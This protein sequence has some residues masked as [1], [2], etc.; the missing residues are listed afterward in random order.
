MF[1][2][3]LLATVAISASA[4]ELV[5]AEDDIL[6]DDE[7]IEVMEEEAPA[8]EA[9]VDDAAED[10]VAEDDALMDDEPIEEMEEEAPAVEAPVDE[11]PVEEALKLEAPAKVDQWKGIRRQYDADRFGPPGGYAADRF[12]PPGGY[13]ADRFGPPG[14]LKAGKL[15][16]RKP[17]PLRRANIGFGQQQFEARFGPAK[18]GRDGPW[19]GA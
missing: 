5:E 4:M 14:G 15:G 18:L 9:L 11:A 13:A 12:G 19:R 8:V 17:L 16:P 10:D 6:M 3:A 7:P 2:S 1:K